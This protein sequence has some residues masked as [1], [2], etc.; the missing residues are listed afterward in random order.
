M[1][2]TPFIILAAGM[3]MAILVGRGM[4][5]KEPSV[6]WFLGVAVGLLTAWSVFK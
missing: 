1:N 4:A 3:F 2:A 5:V 6:H